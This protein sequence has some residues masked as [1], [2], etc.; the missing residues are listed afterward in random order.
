MTSFDYTQMYYKVINQNANHHGFQ[1]QHGN[2]VDILPF[3]KKDCQPGGLYFTDRVGLPYFL[4][5]GCFICEVTIDPSTPVYLE[6][7]KQIYKWKSPS[8]SLNLHDKY[9]FQTFPWTE[10]EK[11]NPLIDFALY[12][13]TLERCFQLIKDP[14]GLY[15]FVRIEKQFRTHELLVSVLQKSP[16]LFKEFQEDEKTQELVNMYVTYSS[17]LS[18]FLKDFPACF[19]NESIVQKAIQLCPS[20]NFTYIR[21]DLI[22]PSL[23]HNA[24]K[25]GLKDLL[26]I[27]LQLLTPSLVQQWTNEHLQSF[28]V[29]TKSKCTYCDRVKSLI[30][31]TIRSNYYPNTYILCDELLQDQS[32]KETFLSQMEEIALKPYRTFP[33]VFYQ[34][35]FLGGYTETKEYIES[36]QR[37]NKNKFMFTTTT[38]QQIEHPHPEPQTFP[39]VLSEDF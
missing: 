4:H 16:L 23:C 24:I 37:L 26:L 9:T 14:I 3:V 35:K 19:Q 28:V 32:I 29:F 21:N 20:K 38:K 13:Q 31:T 11:K 18:D 27:P 8:F 7:Q 6:R 25:N 39:L 12:P 17:A 15:G 33:M 5:F 2:N 34:G 10:E 22:T 1:Y 36:N 30:D